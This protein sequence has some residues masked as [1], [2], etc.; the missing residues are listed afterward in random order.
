MKKLSFSIVLF[1]TIS[2]FNVNSTL[3]QEAE[4]PSL[5]LIMEEFVAPSDRA[6]Y[7]KVQ[8]E[9]LKLFDELKLEMTFFTYQTDD[10]SFYWALPLKS[11]ASI[12]ELFAKMMRSN[13]L[14]KEKGYDPV[15]KFRD[16][17][18]ISQFVVSLNK[19]LSYHPTEKPEGTEPDKFYEWTFFHLKSGHEKEAAE[20]TKKYIEF[21]NSIEENYAWNVYE[22][23]LGNNTP[24]WI[25]ETSAESELAQRTLESDLQK[26]YG[27]DFQKL[28]QNFIQHVG[29]METK[30][31]WYLPNWSRYPG[32]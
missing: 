5:F 30:K 1:L 13:E 29:T 24:C 28:W 17:S 25:L 21:Y 12:D 8:S 27:E 15:A 23:V 16:L 26:K 31:G 11:F 18:T 10:N 7:W 4:E 2:L 9:M 32:K 22:V 19:E 6:E 14:L 20:A 3:A